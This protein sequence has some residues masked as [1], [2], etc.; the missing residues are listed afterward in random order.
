MRTCWREASRFDMNLD[1]QNGRL[2]LA[3]RT[4]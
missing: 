4:R 3:A 1:G 2:E